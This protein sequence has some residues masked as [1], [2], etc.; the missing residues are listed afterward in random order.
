M[1][2]YVITMWI[3]PSYETRLSH[4]AI[5]QQSHSNH[6]VI[7][8]VRNATVPLVYESA[9][10]NRISPPVRAMIGIPWACDDREA[11]GNV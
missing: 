6:M 9:D 4:T 11:E 7:T 10:V 2:Y 8:F 1:D 3:T 5:T